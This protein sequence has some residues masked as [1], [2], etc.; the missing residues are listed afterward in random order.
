MHPRRLAELRRRRD[1]RTEDRLGRLVAVRVELM[2][3][4]VEQKTL[5]RPAATASRCAREGCDHR[6]GSERDLVV[7]RSLDQRSQ[8]RRRLDDGARRLDEDAAPAAGSSRRTRCTGAHASARSSARSGRSSENQSATSA[9]ISVFPERRPS[10]QTC[11]RSPR[12]TPS[13]S[14]RC[15]GVSCDVEQLRAVARL[16]ESG[17][18]RRRASRH[19]DPAAARRCARS[20]HRT[21]RAA[22]RWRR[23]SFNVFSVL[24][25]AFIATK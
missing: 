4:L 20:A 14:S 21:D 16:D 25:A 9:A 15:R 24:V 10:A 3:G 22:A 2:R 6:A 17:A 13:S 19:R 11:T 12:S 8:Q 23:W 18:Q 5:D 1:E 7:G